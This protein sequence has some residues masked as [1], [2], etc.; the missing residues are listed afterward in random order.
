MVGQGVWLRRQAVILAH[1]TTVRATFSQIKSQATGVTGPHPSP[2]VEVVE[3]DAAHAARLATV[4]D[5]EVVVAGQLHLVVPGG[6]VAVAH[7]LQ[8]GINNCEDSMAS[9]NKQLVS[10][11]ASQPS[12][13]GGTPAQAPL[14]RKARPSAPQ[15]Q[16]R[17]TASL[18]YNSSHLV[19]AVEVAHVLLIHVGGGD[20][21]AAAK[22]P[23][24]GDALPVLGLK[25]AAQGEGG[26]RW[27]W[28][29]R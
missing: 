25:V 18:Q 1:S 2:V 21:G 22:P 7:G 24:A 8:D 17:S 23:L 27:H 29:Q 11:T 6:V 14:S 5:E 26:V 3:E 16:A 20:V 9:G 10:S 15:S 4:R 28:W 12:L 13:A 19:G